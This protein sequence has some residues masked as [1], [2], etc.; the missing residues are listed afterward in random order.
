MNATAAI[1]SSGLNMS[2]TDNTME[3][4]WVPFPSAISYPT[5]ESTSDAF[6]RAV[7][8]K[9]SFPGGINYRHGEKRRW[10]KKAVDLWSSALKCAPFGLRFVTT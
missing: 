8:D 6:L 10:A 2:L 4:D 9:M 1:L 7:V 3:L 5:G